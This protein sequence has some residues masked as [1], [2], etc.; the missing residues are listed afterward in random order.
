VEIEIGYGRRRM[1]GRPKAH[2]AIALLPTPDR[3]YFTIA[4]AAELLRAR[5]WTIAAAIREKKLPYVRMGKKFVLMR[6]DLDAFALANR[7]DA[8]NKRG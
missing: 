8:P 5:K 6:A 4:E 7:V 1:T 3:Q 2:D